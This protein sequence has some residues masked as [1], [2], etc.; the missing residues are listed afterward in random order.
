[1]DCIREL[2]GNPALKDYIS[3]VPEKAYSSEDGG[4]RMYDEMWTGD[5]WWNIQVS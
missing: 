1:V 5:W 2:I 4:V 3:Y